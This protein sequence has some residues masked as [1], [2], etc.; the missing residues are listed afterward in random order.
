MQLDSVKSVL[1]RFRN[2]YIPRL[3]ATLSEVDISLE[4]QPDNGG[5]QFLRYVTLMPIKVLIFV[6]DR[7]LTELALPEH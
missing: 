6:T 4:W 3:P 2:S 7:A 5:N 1:H